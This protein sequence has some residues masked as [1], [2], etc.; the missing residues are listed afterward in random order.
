MGYE[1]AISD[2]QQQKT[3]VKKFQSD[4]QQQKQ[5]VKQFQK[6]VD[7]RIGE[8][9]QDRFSKSREQQLY[10][11]KEIKS[12]KERKSKAQ[13][14]IKSLKERE[15]EA[16]EAFE[17]LKTQEE[18]LKEYK[19][20]GYQ[21]KETDDG[22]KFYKKVKRKTKKKT[23]KIT[24]QE[25][26]NKKDWRPSAIKN[27][28]SESAF[29]NAL[30]K[31]HQGKDEVVTN[32]IKFYE[33][34]DG[35]IGY[36][37][38]HKLEYEAEELTPIYKS[39]SGKISSINRKIKSYG[40]MDKVSNPAYKKKKQE[41]Q[42]VNKQRISLFKDGLQPNEIPKLRDL[43]VKGMRLSG[44]LKK[45]P[46]TKTVKYTSG[47]KSAIKVLNVQKKMFGNLLDKVPKSRITTKTKTVFPKQ[48]QSLYDL[49]PE[50]AIKVKNPEYKE[51]NLADRFPG[52]I[53]DR[54][55]EPLV[56]FSEV[57]ESRINKG[58]PEKI[59]NVTG[60][61]NMVSGKTM[62]ET[63]VESYTSEGVPKKFTS[64]IDLP[65]NYQNIGITHQ[66]LASKVYERDVLGI[67]SGKQFQSWIQ[68]KGVQHFEETGD[69]PFFFK[70]E[71]VSPPEGSKI[72]DK[73]YDRIQFLTSYDDDYDKEEAKEDY[74][75]SI[76]K[77][78]RKSESNPLKIDI[79]D[80]YIQDAPKSFKQKIMSEVSSRGMPVTEISDEE[81]D[82][83]YTTFQFEKQ[84]GN[85][86]SHEKMGEH[87][88]SQFSKPISVTTTIAADA[89]SSK[90]QKL[91]EATGSGSQVQEMSQAQFLSSPYAGGTSAPKYIPG[92]SEYKMEQF[93][94]TGLIDTPHGLVSGKGLTFE[95]LQTDI[96]TS[97]GIFYEWSGGVSGES[98]RE[99]K[100]HY[101]MRDD[102]GKPIHLPET[103]PHIY[104]D[105][106]PKAD[107][108]ENVVE[109][110]KGTK[111]EFVEGV[112]TTKENISKIESHLEDLS[113]YPY[114]NVQY[115]IDRDEELEN[116]S[117]KR[118]IGDLESSLSSQQ[119]TLSK[120]QSGKGEVQQQLSAIGRATDI[121]YGVKKT[122]EG[123]WKIIEP[124]TEEVYEHV[125]GSK[126][127]TIGDQIIQGDFGIDSIFAGGA[128]LI[129]GDDK[130]WE[131]TQKDIMERSLSAEYNV[132]R[133]EKAGGSRAFAGSMNVLGS[134]AAQTVGITLGTF[135]AGA[136]VGSG[137]KAGK[138]ALKGTRVGGKLTRF[139]AKAASKL[140]KHT[141][142]VA[143]YGA[144]GAMEAHHVSKTLSEEGYSA[145]G[146]L[147]TH[148]LRFGL[149]WGAFGKGLKAGYGKPIST[150]GKASKVIDSKPSMT[151]RFKSGVK[152]S[153]EKTGDYM[154]AKH[155]KLTGNLKAISGRAKDVVRQTGFN[156]KTGARQLK[157]GGKQFVKRQY[158]KL[159]SKSP[160][161][162]K[163]EKGIRADISTVRSSPKYQGLKSAFTKSDSG[164]KVEL[165]DEE[166]Q[167]WH[168]LPNKSGKMRSLN[169]QFVGSD[170]TEI[171][172]QSLL[173]N[174][175]L[176]PDVVSF[177]FKSSLQVT[178]D[179]AS[180]AKITRNLGA[181][182]KGFSLVKKEM[183]IW[184][185]ATGKPRM[186]IR[187]SGNVESF[188][189]SSVKTPTAGRFTKSSSTKVFDFASRSSVRDIP[190]L[191]N[192]DD[193]NQYFEYLTATKSQ[194][195]ATGGVTKSIGYGSY[196]P[197]DK[198]TV[199]LESFKDTSSTMLSGKNFNL[200]TSQLNLN[201]S[202]GIVK[203]G[204]GGVV[205]VKGTYSPPKGFDKAGFQIKGKMITLSDDAPVLAQYSTSPSKS[206]N[207][208]SLIQNVEASQSLVAPTG[209]RAIERGIGE[210]IVSGIGDVAG[211]AAAQ[212]FAVNIP[213]SAFSLSKTSTKTLSGSSIGGLLA[214][215]DYELKSE[216][217]QREDKK[218]EIRRRL[219]PQEVST[220]KT[221]YKANKERFDS[222]VQPVFDTALSMDMK[223]GQRE[224]LRLG[225]ETILDLKQ[226]QMQ[227]QKL[228]L[229]HKM[230]LNL[231]SPVP[232]PNIN[233]PIPTVPSPTP[234]P[235][236]VVIDDDPFERMQKRQ[237][238]MDISFG[239]KR[240]KYSPSVEQKVLANPFRVMQSQQKYGRA[241]HPETTR[242]LVDFGRSHG[243]DIPTVELM[244]EKK[245][246]KKKSKEKIGFDYDKNKKWSL[247][248]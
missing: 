108:S 151:S 90:M 3:D 100:S 8:L 147:G 135:G 221:T 51:V 5:K 173:K 98:M 123:G 92:H 58:T 245:K 149:G 117:R 236:P 102:E 216:I 138:L 84:S 244:E 164:V 72:S 109:D 218:L 105:Y 207:P 220:F 59:P 49:A 175:G 39:L 66:Q 15:H 14:D 204:R 198:A 139:G 184:R 229:R 52:N 171:L 202:F 78:L 235:P 116:V 77:S 166:L 91:M 43:M 172:A 228:R 187:P 29:E 189:V 53:P 40:D 19:D 146:K 168:N 7:K 25:W 152:S 159:W 104:Y 153:V 80:D 214:T 48:G 82:K 230:K 120:L 113:V 183:V 71:E 209:Q 87:V 17:N 23:R 60:W 205:A 194:S 121:G 163:L 37:E 110:L 79:S 156:I 131:A 182:G 132:E 88:L 125:K 33:T 188:G 232:S 27:K 11:N 44:Q 239:L 234:V 95:Q 50:E 165:P 64:K 18:K 20:K 213:K 238:D 115:D 99:Q 26:M 63:M 62:Q 170:D 35:S 242:N 141:F 75:L 222:R 122:D 24:K 12:L 155:P 38:G 243:W 94:E 178:D 137:A 30:W 223:V 112:S 169:T 86:I 103:K 210:S 186:I 69:Y 9:K 10:S 162:Q 199:T 1:R 144:L 76:Y 119:M 157:V 227:K 142:K 145:P 111:S 56:G 192:I 128:T 217:K 248:I 126:D 101:I 190:G 196:R 148:A 46:K 180:G 219:Q 68:D 4:V 130:Y 107:E 201:K 28:I 45:I 13:K 174:K 31:I 93:K 85:K 150:S 176:K 89:E 22:Y 81:W 200:K 233:I 32:N 41:L 97:K 197:V 16:E 96:G 143:T 55:K 191:Q 154:W 160:S 106:N 21:I 195:R 161:I 179:L 237:P 61:T 211:Q 36:S 118:V 158:Y 2:V 127:V 167:T 124:T 181:E 136:L 34:D 226:S 203:E 247:K 6:D 134:P 67:T 114:K 65:K 212:P 177:R 54:L 231:D 57:V 225:T 47:E 240:K 193:T 133:T 83:I 224:D 185:D 215:S 129:T 246:K 208:D 140:P 241:T 74:A 206:Y 42:N 70:P 73:E